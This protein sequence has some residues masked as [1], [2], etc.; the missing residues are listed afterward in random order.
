MAIR[1]APWPHLVRRFFATL[2]ARVDPITLSALDNVLS[3]AERRLF[4]T[5][6]EADQQHS[7]DLCDRLCRDGH[8][9]PD[10]LRA[11]LLHDVGKASGRLPIMYRVAYTMS[12]MVSPRLTRWLGRPDPDGWR[13]PFYLAA[14]H[15]E[16][17]A[18]AAL[19]AGSSARVVGLIAG[20]S[21]PGSDELSRA[22]YTYDR[23]S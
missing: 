9:N 18:A 2:L 1:P 16:I 10:L 12:A 6:V 3:P 4:L 11:A 5:M 22:L 8:D 14:H 13:R 17:G 23:R 7:L 15:P 21:K 20:H 19:R